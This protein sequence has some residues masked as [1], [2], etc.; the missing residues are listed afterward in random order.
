MYL[1][2]KKEME[3]MKKDLLQQLLRGSMQYE[4]KNGI[5]EITGYRTG[6]RIYIDLN[7]IDEDAILTEE[8][9]EEYL[10]DE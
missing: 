8:E 3:K 2:T 7:E 6:E 9:Y 4:I 5:L 10:G 1:Q